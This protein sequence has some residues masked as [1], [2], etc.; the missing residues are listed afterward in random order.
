MLA[1]EGDSFF[2]DLTPSRLCRTPPKIFFANFRG[3]A[4]Y[5]FNNIAVPL[6]QKGDEVLAPEGDRYYFCIA[7]NS[8]SPFRAVPLALWGNCVFALI[9]SLSEFGFLIK[10]RT[11]GEAEAV[12]A[13]AVAGV[14][15]AIR[16]TAVL[17]IVAPTTSAEHAVRAGSG[18]GR[19]D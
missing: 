2:S 11:K 5:A 4:F 17:R 13:A 16:H 7:K 6:L 9:F 8:N 3:R 15:V 14:V 12:V 18:T 1:P 10:L 19:V